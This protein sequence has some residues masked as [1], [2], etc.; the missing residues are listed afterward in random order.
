ME[1]IG[2]ILKKARKEQG[3]SLEEINKQTKISLEH[4]NLL[5]NNDYSFLPETYVKSFVRNYAIA[6]GLDDRELVERY[7]LHQE[8]KRKHQEEQDEVEIENQSSSSKLKVIEWAL[9]LGSLILLISLIL[10]YFQFKSQIHANPAEPRQNF[11]K[12]DNASAE[13]A[14]LS[15]EDFYT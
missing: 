2:H 10:I 6:L 14:W 11:L 7:V 12:E 9:G 3:K 15:N 4:L 8:K 1:D 5:E 13:I